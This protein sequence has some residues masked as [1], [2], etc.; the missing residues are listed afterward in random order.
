MKIE[1]QKKTKIRSG[2]L[3][4]AGALAIAIALKGCY[5]DAEAK[6]DDLPVV[7]RQTATPVDALIIKPGVVKDELEVTGTL[8][9]NQKVDIVSELTRKLVR[10]H[11]R[12]GSFVK[13]GDILFQ[14]DDADLQAQL[15]K[16][17]QQEKLALLN[18]Q[19]LKDLLEREAIIQ[20]EYDEAFTHLK[21]LQAQIAEL[22]VMISKTQITAPFDGQ[23]GII[24]V[25]PGAIVST[26][27]ILTDLEDNGVVKVEFSVPEKYAPIILPGTE[28]LFTVTSEKKPHRARVTARGA[29][30][31]NA[32]HTL[33]VRAVAS[34]PD[35]RLLPGQ[36]A[37]LT[38]TLGSAEDAVTVSSQAL[39]PSLTGYS[40]F[41]V[42]HHTAELLPVEIGQRNAETVEIIKGL[43]LGDTIITS[44]LLRLTPGTPVHI[45][46][47]Q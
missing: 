13:A 16:L 21:V 24:D 10:V 14:L 41:T 29:S 11:V 25:H 42:K 31:D 8:V 2:L 1:L 22:R 5:A 35:R 30:M 17:R 33:L 44:N 19:R 26:S 28:H 46:S 36:S 32:T 47:I 7:V 6:K 3:L 34:N 15:E 43:S 38:L 39:I 18:E 4:G 37:R 27:T 45:V 12:E 40:V 20:Q 9:A 23:V